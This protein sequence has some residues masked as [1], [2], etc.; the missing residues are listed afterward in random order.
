MA[1]FN[2]PLDQT[3]EAVIKASA[4]NDLDAAVAVAFAALPDTTKLKTYTSQFATCAGSGATFTLTS[5]VAQ[6]AYTNGMMLTFI[7]NVSS[8]STS[9]TLNVDGLGAV[10]LYLLSGTQAG[11]GSLTMGVPKIVM[12]SSSLNR[13]Y[14]MA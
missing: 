13:F 3:S 6:Y 4:I 14:I 10:A 1:T 2:S 7:P 11:I 12:Y 9:V 8:T 5:P